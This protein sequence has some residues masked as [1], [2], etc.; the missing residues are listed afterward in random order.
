MQNNRFKIIIASYNNEAWVEYNL[1]SIL[2]QTYENYEVIYVDDKSEDRTIQKVK[3]IVGGNKKF[4]IIENET[5]LGGTYNHI[6]FFDSIEDNEILVLVDGDDWLFDDSVLDNLN[7]FY[8]EKDVWMTYGKFYAW[9]G[10]YATEANPQNTPFPEF[11]HDNK[12][13]RLDTWRS[14]HLRTYKGFLVKA[15]DKQDFISKIDNKLFNHAA[16]LALAFPC[17]EMCPKEKIGVLDF[18]SYIY[19]ASKSAGERTR[20]RESQDNIKYEIEIRNKKKYKEGHFGNKLPQVNVIGYFQET[21]YIPKDFSFVYDVVNG[22]QDIN[23]I[24]DFDILRYIKGEK[25]ITKG[26]IVA[27]L[28]ESPLH[29]AHMKETYDL[30][31]QNYNMFDLILTYDSK[32]LTL[33]NAEKRLCMW[34]CLNKN[35]H[36]KEWPILSDDSL[37]KIYNKTKNISCISSNK[38]FLPGHVLR[39]EMVNHILSKNTRNYIDMF[40]VGFNEITGKIEG[41]KD[42]RFSIAIEN[43]YIDNWAT[44]KLSDCFLTG[45]IPIYYGCPNVS[46]IFDIEGIITF[47]NKEELE[48]I[49]NELHENGEKIYNSKLESIKRNFEIV[50]QYS[51]NIDQVFNKHLKKLIHE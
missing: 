31:Y 20:N 3:E 6:R 16:D 47:S 33:P 4:T 46:E 10:E 25:K 15:I 50:N 49:I 23:L 12:L 35:V 37:Y 13:Y 43:A 42:Y 36:T 38:S 40:G 28:H 8:N 21:N 34:R 14:S 7:N 17:L 30:V 9:D 27:D 19:N 51:L 24:T 26:K 1:A 11:V 2:N 32:L 5:N 44:E 22:E 45:T 39:L 48:G 18:P 41:L 29:N